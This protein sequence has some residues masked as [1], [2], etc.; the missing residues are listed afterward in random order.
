MYKLKEDNYLVCFL[1]HFA[2]IYFFLTVY[3][4]LSTRNKS[5]GE[6]KEQKKNLPSEFFLAIAVSA[7]ESSL[8]LVFIGLPFWPSSENGKSM[9]KNDFGLCVCVLC[10]EKIIRSIRRVS[11]KC[12]SFCV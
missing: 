11:Y 5:G 12:Q 4:T 7:T 8:K 1:V 10:K 3:E 2:I 6:R 9:P